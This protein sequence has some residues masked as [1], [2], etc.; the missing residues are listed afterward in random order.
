[1][2]R[3]LAY[4]RALKLP[5]QPDFGAKLYEALSD[6][7]SQHQT[8]AQQVNGNSSGQPVAPPPISKLT[9]TAASGHFSA[10]IQDQGPVYRGIGYFI[11]HA[12]NPH[13]VNPQVVDLGAA[14]NWTGFLGDATRYFRA[15]SSYGSSPAGVPAY[16]GSKSQPLPVS[17]GGA[18]PGAIFGT[19]QGSGTGQPGQGLVGPGQ[20]PFRSPT[21]KPPSRA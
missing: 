11:E 18:V 1:V 10:E 20:I 14:R 4:I 15:Y 9:V 19:S 13:F 3:N 8:V 16:H 5:D 17:G 12:D 6:L 2:I 21:G 7:N